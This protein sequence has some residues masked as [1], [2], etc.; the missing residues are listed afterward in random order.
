MGGDD[1]T[2]LNTWNSVQ[3]LDFNLAEEQS[4]QAR[5]DH[6]FTQVKGLSFMTRYTYGDNIERVGQAD[7]TEWERNVELKYVFQETDGL[8]LRWRN[9]TVRSSE[10]YDTN[11]NRLLLNYKIAFK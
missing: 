6:N 7:G 9:S 1:E 11:E 4:W 10:T 5:L 2:G 3:R 8:S